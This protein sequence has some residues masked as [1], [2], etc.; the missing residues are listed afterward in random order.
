MARKRQA[1]QIPVV[2]HLRVSPEAVP[3]L[4]RWPASPIASPGSNGRLHG[5]N[6]LECL[7]A[8]DHLHG[9]LGLEF[10]AMGAAFAH[11]WAFTYQGGG[12]ASEVNDGNCPKKPDHLRCPD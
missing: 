5:G 11:G 1:G 12:G 4:R 2:N 6:L 8:T 9:D 7:A 3:E 10:G